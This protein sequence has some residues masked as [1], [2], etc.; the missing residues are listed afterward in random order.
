LQDIVVRSALTSKMGEG[1]RNGWAFLQGERSSKTK[2]NQHIS[3][4]SA[5][6]KKKK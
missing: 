6:S 4:D 1:N 5:A 2:Q 3:A